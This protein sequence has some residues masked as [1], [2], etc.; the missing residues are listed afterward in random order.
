MG[1]GRLCGARVFREITLSFAPVTKSDQLCISGLLRSNIGRWK[2][3]APERC[4]RS[5]LLSRNHIDGDALSILGSI[6]PSVSHEFLMQK[7]VRRL[8]LI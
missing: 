4:R 2:A 3:P 8:Y 6:Y 7:Q 5:F 1:H